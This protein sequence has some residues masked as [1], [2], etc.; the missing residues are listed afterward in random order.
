M[1]P[2]EYLLDEVERRMKKEQPKN[3]KELKEALSRVWNGIQKRTLKKLVYSV[4]NRL[5]EVPCMRGYPT[6]Y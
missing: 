3:E 2:I 1:N 4:L 5:N 6:R